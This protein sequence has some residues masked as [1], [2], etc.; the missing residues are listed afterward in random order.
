MFI[1][2]NYNGFINSE[3]IES[4][5]VKKLRNSDE[6][7]ILA[8]NSEHAYQVHTYKNYNDAFYA[9]EILID[10]INHH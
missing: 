1:K 9:L 2:T 5:E 3:M 10:D 7:A 8:L 6:Y 4:F